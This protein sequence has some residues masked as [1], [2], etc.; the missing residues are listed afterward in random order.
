MI[1]KIIGVFLTSLLFTHT[2]T[3]ATTIM[4]LT[5]KVIESRHAIQIA[6]NG[7]GYLV[8]KT[9]YKR[10]RSALGGAVTN[11]VIDKLVIY[12]YAK[13]GGFLGC[14]ETRP[15]SNAPS[16]AFET[17]VKTL[18][19]IKPPKKTTAY[20][21][22]RIETCPVSIKP[23]TVFVAK[24][25]E[26]LQCNASSGVS[27]VDMQTQLNN[28]VIYSSTK[29]ADGAMH[30][31]LC[32]TPVGMLNVYEIAETDLQSAVYLGFFEFSLGVE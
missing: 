3:S 10:V 5:T 22:T 2:A 30:L 18:N 20:T 11:D 31:T 1:K 25:D 17:L 14:V 21:I 23:K 4:P 12:N 16:T 9:S 29:K 6:I 26:S 13:E 8:D 7:N 19:A 32:G 24:S 27:L 28:I 15:S